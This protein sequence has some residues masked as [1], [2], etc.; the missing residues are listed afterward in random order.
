MAS[1]NP[2]LSDGGSILSIPYEAYSGANCMDNARIKSG[3]NEL[4]RLM[5]GMPCGKW[6]GLRLCPL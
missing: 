1:C 2:N 5:N 3:F 4:Y 6:I